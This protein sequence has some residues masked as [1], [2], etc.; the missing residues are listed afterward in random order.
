LQSSLLGAVGVGDGDTN[1]TVGV[2]DGVG[3]GVADG[4]AVGLRVGF[5]VGDGLGVW[6]GENVGLAVQEGDGVGVP[7]RAANGADS[8]RQA[9]RGSVRP[10]KSNAFLI[11][12]FAF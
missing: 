10:M 7:L 8:A 9:T 4:D 6:V 11:V 3:S 1:R 2:S 5:A 12:V